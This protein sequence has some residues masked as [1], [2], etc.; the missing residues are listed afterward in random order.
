MLIKQDLLE[1]REQIQEDLDCILG[2]YGS[3]RYN[4]LLTDMDQAVVDRFE[5]LF[6]K[7]IDATVDVEE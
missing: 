2:N 5:V 3:K 7:L 4:D 6:S 1:V